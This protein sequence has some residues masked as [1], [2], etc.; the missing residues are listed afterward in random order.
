M[1]TMNFDSAMRSQPAELMR[2]R[3]T[4]MAQLS[5]I[6]LTVLT[7]SET[8]GIVAMG[9]SHNSGHAVVALLAAQGRRA[10]NLTA[11][12]ILN[13]VDSY[14]P[15]DRYFVVSESGRSPE[16]IDAAQHLTTG[17]R[18]GLSNF[19]D[20]PLGGA[21]DV[22]VSLGAV[23][24]S[25]IYTVGYTG[26]LLAYGLV[27]EQMGALPHDDTLSTVPRRVSDALVA[28]ER[29]ASTAGEWIAAASTVD[30]VGRGVSLSAAAELALM[31]R[32][33]LRMPTG[34]YETF[35]YTH[36]PIE[37]ASPHTVVVMFGDERELELVAPLNS[38]GVRVIVITASPLIE[39]LATDDSLLTVVTLDSDLAGL[40]RAIIEAVFAQLVVS[41]A[42]GRLDLR[43]GEF[44][45]DDLGTKLAER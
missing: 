19:A 41:S 38:R 45:Y 27:L 39:T 6:P 1:S 43:L 5:R 9:A 40:S 2:V 21:V 20:S 30:V 42:A 23:P 3:E 32:E 33:G 13:G 4:V 18:V 36:G 35:E 12:D 14:Q 34:C 7:P 24:D 22:M 26:T 17:S 8:L 15:A 37:A 25:A 28:F 11:T 10:V 44:S 16:P 29:V 31:L